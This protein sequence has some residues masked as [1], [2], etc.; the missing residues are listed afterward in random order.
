MLTCSRCSLPKVFHSRSEA[1][2]PAQLIHFLHASS[3]LPALTG[4][5]DPGC[6][7]TAVI[8]DQPALALDPD[9]AIGASHQHCTMQDQPS[10]QPNSV[11][12]DRQLDSFDA[13]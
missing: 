5:P 11:E 12:E 3:A 10:P 6:A 4:S 2:P 13:A 9:G 8:A 1:L 7:I